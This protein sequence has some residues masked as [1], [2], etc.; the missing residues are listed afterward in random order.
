MHNGYLTVVNQITYNDSLLLPH[1]SQA[2]PGISDRTLPLRKHRPELQHVLN[3]A[4][5]AVLLIIDIIRDRRGFG[6]R[7]LLVLYDSVFW[8]SFDIH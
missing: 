7:I 5:T 8:F 4:I 2:A 1:D 6:S 3:R